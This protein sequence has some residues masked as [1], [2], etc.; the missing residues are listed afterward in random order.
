MNSKFLI[1]G[2]HPDDPDLMFGGCAIKLIGSGDLVK[3]VSC[4]NGA[5]GRALP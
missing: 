1:I 3:F 2:A 5:T 4:T